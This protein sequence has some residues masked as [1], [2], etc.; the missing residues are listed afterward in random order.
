[1]INDRTTLHKTV[2]T[3]LGQIPS[4]IF[5]CRSLN[6]AKLCFVS[7]IVIMNVQREFDFMKKVV[8]ISYQGS[9]H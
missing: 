5:V 3:H 4:S 2:T 8:K 7:R 6:V 9:I 1:M